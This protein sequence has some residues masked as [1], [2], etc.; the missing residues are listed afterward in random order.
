MDGSSAYYTFLSIDTVLVAA[1]MV[2]YSTQMFKKDMQRGE[3]YSKTACKCPWCYDTRVSKTES[4]K[5]RKR[6]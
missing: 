6:I 1:T 4:E 2:T 3:D 5:K